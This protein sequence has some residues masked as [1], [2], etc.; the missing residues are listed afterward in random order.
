MT[1]FKC[2][3]PDTLDF[4]LSRPLA[5]PRDRSA[6]PVA[7]VVKAMNQFL[8]THSHV[9]PEVDAISFYLMNHAVAEVAKRV[10]K[11]APLGHYLPLVA[12]YHQA[13]NEASA[14]AFYYLLIICTRESRHASLNPTLQ[15]TLNAKYPG[16]LPFWKGIHGQGSHGASNRLKQHPPEAS[17]GDYVHFL[18][19][20]FYKGGFGGGFGGPAWGKVADCLRDFVIGKY[21]AEMMMDTVWTLCHNNGPIFNKGELYHCYD[22]YAIIKVLDVQRSGQI[23]QLV[24]NDELPQFT[25]TSHR[26]YQKAAQAALGD[27]MGGYVDWEVVEALGATKKY[28]AEKKAQ[29]AKHG[30]STK[31]KEAQELAAKKA[32]AALLAQQQA[33]A[34]KEKDYF[35]VSNIAGEEVLVK[36]VKVRATA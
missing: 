11:D 4:Q 2:L 22:P 26:A 36:K 33:Q 21:T 14:R 27:C 20:V 13:Q 34:Q 15:A 17:M 16:C 19:D 29:F 6:V 25:T 9:H 5:R 23:P 10:D 8:A 7:N 24:A 28:P 32:Y 35:V 12:D 18:C 30:L 3:D 1:A 31:A